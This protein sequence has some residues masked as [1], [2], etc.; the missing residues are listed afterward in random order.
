L[1]VFSSSILK[2]ILN[3]PFEMQSSSLYS[4]YP[5]RFEPNKPFIFK[6]K[7]YLDRAAADFTVFDVVTLL[8]AGVK[9]HRDA[10]PAVGAI[11]KVFHYFF[12]FVNHF[13][14]QL[15]S[16]HPLQLPF[17]SHR[18]NCMFLQSMKA[19]PRAIMR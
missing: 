4:F 3:P 7:C 16:V 15:G 19:K 1:I 14:I 6:S 13:V 9:Y 2:D 17:L 5:L 8:F 18:V 11:K 10:F 12:S